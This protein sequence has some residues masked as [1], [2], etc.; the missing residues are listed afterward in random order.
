MKL[1]FS[2]LEKVIAQLEEALGYYHSPLAKA[3]VRLAL[4]LR[5]ATIQAFEFTY[6]ISLKM[7]KR[8]LQL[9][10]TNPN[11]IDELTF[12]ELIRTAYEKG[13]IQSELAMW[14]EY[15]KERGTTSHTYD[16]VKAQGV[17]EEIPAFLEDAKYLLAQLKKRQ[18]LQR[19]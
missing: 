3:D 18:A 10:D 9:T 16:E 19:E 13:L 5:A 4:H 6:E 14:K 17:F 8:Y 7:L 15:R 2:S 12:N 1:D 11:V